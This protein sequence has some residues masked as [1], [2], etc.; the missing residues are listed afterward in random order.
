MITPSA[1]EQ[2]VGENRRPTTRWYEWLLDND[3]WMPYVV[4]VSSG[5]GTFTTVSAVGR[6]KKRG[7]QIFINIVVTITTVGTAASYV[8]ASLPVIS[9]PVAQ[10]ISGKETATDFSV[11][12]EIAAGASNI[13][14]FKYDGTTI[15]ASSRVVVLTGVYEAAK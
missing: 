3:A 5:T 9:G 11:N 12:G 14:I 15:A 10:C 8:R 7:R 4:S 2:L 1:E 13:D 6:Y